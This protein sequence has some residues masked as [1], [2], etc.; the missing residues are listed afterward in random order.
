[1]PKVMKSLLS[2]IN[3]II[4]RYPTEFG[5]TPI[6]QLFCNNCNCVVKCDKQLLVDNHRRT[7]KHQKQLPSSSTSPPQSQSFI[8]LSPKNF[9]ESV[10]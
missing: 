4:T 1:M 10:T 8:Q 5:K 2:K 7:A 3:S 9:T 6:P